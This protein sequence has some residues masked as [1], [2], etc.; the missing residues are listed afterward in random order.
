MLRCY[1]GRELFG[2]AEGKEVLRAFDGVL[3]AAEELLEI[4]AAFDEVDVGGVDDQEIA[5]GVAK[6]EVLVGVGY[7]CDVF[8]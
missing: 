6:E 2:G 4:S 8:G 3:E 1:D 5:S 7:L